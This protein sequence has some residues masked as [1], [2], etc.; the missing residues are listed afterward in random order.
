MMPSEK[1]T[2]RVILALDQAYEK[3]TQLEDESTD[4]AEIVAYRCYYTNI[5]ESKLYVK[6][7]QKEINQMK[8]RLK[9]QQAEIDRPK[10][11]KE[12]IIKKL[13]YMIETRS[14]VLENKSDLMDLIH[15]KGQSYADRREGKVVGLMLALE[16]VEGNDGIALDRALKD[17]EQE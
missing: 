7:M 1:N 9:K 11:E 6:Q 14:R 10:A 17:G 2:K 4:E 15:Y 13:K 8:K 3:F 16:I 12:T 5:Y